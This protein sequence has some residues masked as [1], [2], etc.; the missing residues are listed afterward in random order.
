MVLDMV[1]K[2]ENLIEKILMNTVKAY[3]Y[4]SLEDAN[5]FIMDSEKK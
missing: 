5:K 3:G 4:A 2:N 1:Q